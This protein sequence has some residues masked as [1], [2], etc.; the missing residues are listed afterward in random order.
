MGLPVAMHCYHEGTHP[1]AALSMNE[2]MVAEIA[3][4]RAR[5]SR[6]EAHAAAA[7]ERAAAQMAAQTATAHI[8]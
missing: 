5:V 1:M 3:E 4:L 6:A 2:Q 7:T 8:F